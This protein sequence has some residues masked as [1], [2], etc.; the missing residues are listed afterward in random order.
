MTTT[1][2]ATEDQIAQLRLH[3]VNDTTREIMR[4]GITLTHEQADDLGQE[5]LAWIG[6]RLGL[7]VKE[8]DVGTECTPAAAEAHR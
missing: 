5:V 1:N 7:I 3:A 2:T 4:A 6:S 8:T